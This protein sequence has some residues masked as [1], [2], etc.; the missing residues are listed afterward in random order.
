MTG[1]RPVLIC[2]GEH[3]LKSSESDAAVLCRYVIGFDGSG[4]RASA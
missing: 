2:L 1:E 4:A 3:R